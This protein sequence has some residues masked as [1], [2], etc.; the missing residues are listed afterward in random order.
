MAA[1]RREKIADCIHF[2]TEKATLEKWSQVAAG[3]M[4]LETSVRSE[5]GGY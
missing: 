1:D 3:V 5:R 2:I 4:A